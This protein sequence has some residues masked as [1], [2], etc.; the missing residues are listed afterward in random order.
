MRILAVIPH[1]FDSDSQ[2]APDGRRHGSVAK[3][4]APRIEALSACIAALHQQFDPS[5]SIID[6]AR[7]VTRPANAA[8]AAG[9]DV[10]VCTTGDKHLVPALDLGHSAFTHLIT[11]DPAPFLGYTCRAVLRDRIGLYDYYCYL[12]DDLIVRDPFLFAKLAWFNGH[13]GDDR[14]LQP[15]RYELARKGIVRKAYVDGD[16]ADHVLAPFA[17]LTVDPTLRSKFLNVDLA[18][19]RPKNPHSGCYFLNA[20]QMASWG[21]R[22]DF[23]DRESSFVGPLESAATLGILRAFTIY[24]PSP[25]NAAFLEIEHHGTG[26]VGLIRMP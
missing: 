11:D 2:Q 21:A 24:K 18:F 7:K 13:L 20:R 14:L 16:L 8:I 17:D 3:D 4:P 22:A 25:E 19:H 6:I 1:Y 9:V 26:F 12:E 10:I 23:L 5:Q 15:N